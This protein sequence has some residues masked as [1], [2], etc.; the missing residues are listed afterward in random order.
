MPEP[1]PYPPGSTRKPASCPKTSSS[2]RRPT[3]QPESTAQSPCPKDGRSPSWCTTTAERSSWRRRR[4]PCTTTASTAWYG[5]Q[6]LLLSRL[7]IDWRRRTRSPPRTRIRGPH[8]NG[9]PAA[10][11]KLTSRGSG[12]MRTSREY[13]LQAIAPALT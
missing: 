12:S 13:S 11:G 5:R 1:T 10:E 2:H 7:I 9:S 3:Y 6:K 8:W 4:S